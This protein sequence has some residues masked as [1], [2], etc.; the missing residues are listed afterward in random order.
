MDTDDET[1]AGADKFRQVPF[2]PAGIALKIPQA[3]RIGGVHG[4]R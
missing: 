1:G 3:S 4:A 2:S